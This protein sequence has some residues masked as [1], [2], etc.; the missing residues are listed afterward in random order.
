MPVVDAVTI[1]TDLNQMN[2]CGYKSDQQAY[3]YN[4][5]SGIYQTP[6]APHS[7]FLS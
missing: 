5:Q 4:R 6:N 2:R 1:A 3:T 7:H